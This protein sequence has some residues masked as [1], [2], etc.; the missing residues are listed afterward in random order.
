[1]S[2]IKS[3][4]LEPRATN[5]SLTIG[6]PE[7]MTTFEGDVKIPGYATQEYVQQVVTGEI[8]LDLIA[9]Q[10]RDEKWVAGGYAGLDET[11]RVP[12][13]NVDSDSIKE[14]IVVL[15][16]EI[17]SLINLDEK[18]NWGY[19]ANN[20]PE[21]GKAYLS[22]T[23]FTTPQMTAVIHKDDMDG[24]NH[25]FVTAKVGSWIEFVEDDSDYCLGQI[26]EVTPAGDD[27]FQATFNVSVGKGQIEPDGILKIRVFEA[28]EDFDPNSI[29]I[30]KITTAPPSNP[31]DGDLWYDNTEDTMQLLVYHQE[32]D[33]WIAAAPPSTLD[34]RVAAGEA[35]QAQIGEAVVDLQSDKLTK[36]GDDM[37]G[38]FYAT[39][40]N[41]LKFYGRDSSGRNKTFIDMVNTN[42]QGTEGT[43]YKLGLYHVATPSNPYHA[44]NQKYVDDS[45]AEVDGSLTEL[46][47]RV[48]SML[49]DDEIRTIVKSHGGT[50]ILWQYN[51]TA[52]A[53]SLSNGQFTLSSGLVSGAADE[54]SIYFAERDARGQRWYP[55]DSGS[56]YTHEVGDQMATIRERDAIV[57]HGKVTKWY[58]N[59]GTNNYARVK[60]TYYRSQFAKANGKWYLINIPG[61]MPFFTYSSNSYSNGTHT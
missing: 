21:T 43:D 32:S 27:H 37:H 60:M 45:I 42:G 9:Y 51:S 13:D 56:A 54:W 40:G 49:T 61:Y 19:D 6:N 16:G 58:F 41:H 26:T 36:T 44:A 29:R 57:A 31:N 55:H 4:R 7:S 50:P 15:Q 12:A 47:G 14:S 22:S 33:A 10:T 17:G 46:T 18:G 25:T 2:K 5:G 8:D 59:Q 11:G 52:S 35:L 3:N 39:G 28:V 48:D 24:T 20:P 38:N 1:M 30:V 23:D 34:S 53:D